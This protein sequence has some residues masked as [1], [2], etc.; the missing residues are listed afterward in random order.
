MFEQFLTL[1]VILTVPATSAWLAAYD[2]NHRDWCGLRLMPSIAA[3]VAPSWILTALLYLKFFRFLDHY[4]LGI[5]LIAAIAAE[6]ATRLILGNPNPESI[7]ASFSVSNRIA[8]K[9][10]KVAEELAQRRD[11]RRILIDV[12]ATADISDR[13]R[14]QVVR[15]LPSPPSKEDVMRVIAVVGLAR[16]KHLAH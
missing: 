10:V 1:A 8:E 9:K 14:N 13:K 16:V 4:G 6:R 12:L 3:T 2:K 11:C 15:M 5:S 7:R